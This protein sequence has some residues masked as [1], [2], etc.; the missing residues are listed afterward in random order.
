[1]FYTPISS[2]VVR[3]LKSFS[4][5]VSWLVLPYQT[6]NWLEPSAAVSPSLYGKTRNG[7][8]TFRRFSSG[9]AK[10]LRAAPLRGC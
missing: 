9:Y 8:S 10:C 5:P 2:L 4:V 6:D 7:L 3:W 1:M